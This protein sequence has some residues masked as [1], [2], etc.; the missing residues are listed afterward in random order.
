MSPEAR[1]LP[2]QQTPREET[3]RAARRQVARLREAQAGWAATPV[4]RRLEVVRELR[5]LIAEHTGELAATVSLPQRGSAAETLAAEILPL[6]DACRFLER[7][8]AK[9]LAPRRLGG[10]GRPFWLSG[11]NVELRREPFGVVLVI[12]A[13][14]YP[15]L[16]PGVQLVQALVAGNAVWVKPGRGGSQAAALLAALLRRAGV[17]GGVLQVLGESPHEA[18]A[19]ID[20]GVD[21]VLLTG[22]LETGREVLR[23]LAPA[24]TPAVMELS[25]CDPVFVREDAD[26]ELVV[27]A[28]GFG[29]TFNGGFTCIAPRRILVHRS[30]APELEVALAGR[31]RSLPPV[32][33]DA[34]AAARVRRLALEAFQ[35]GARLCGELPRGET[36]GGGQGGTESMAPLLVAGVRPEMAIAR[37]D[38]AAPVLS[39]IAV[40]GDRQALDAARRCRFEL[41]ATIFGAETGARALAREVPA[42]V[43]VINDLIVPTADPRLPFGGRGDSGFGVTRGAQGLLELT[44]VKAVV[45]RG[46]SFRPHFDPPGPDQERLLEDFVQI[47]HA[48]TLGRRVGAIF[49]AVKLLFQR[50]APGRRNR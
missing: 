33:V 42:G 24:V 13:S 1:V 39:L 37:A 35:G 17:P 4:R 45:G 5:H 36:A 14:N 49:D 47:A 8:A 31:L 20:A 32:P 23:R 16:L 9:L 10:R 43:V 29:T 50:P 6:A 7:E 25:G 11:S 28:L 27:R 19:A 38:L 30:R 2:F 26:L 48:R 41:G 12:A 22:S 40:G 15:L 34:E 44:R 18:A 3:S 21:K 46:G